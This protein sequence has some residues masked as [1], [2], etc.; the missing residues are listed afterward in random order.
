[1]WTG[2]NC[3]AS[4]PNPRVLRACLFKIWKSPLRSRSGSLA[5]AAP[6]TGLIR[7]ASL[8]S[9]AM[10]ARCK[11]SAGANWPWS[12]PVALS[13]PRCGNQ[14]AQ[15]WMRLP[16]LRTT[17]A[18]RFWLWPAAW[19]VATGCVNW[20]KKCRKWICGCQ[21]KKCFFGRKC[22]SKPLAGAAN[23]PEAG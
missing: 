1:M 4:S 8:A 21:P 6:K 19:S 12:I 13:S 15:S 17:S 14:S 16:K 9:W 10:C 3:F 5:W 7:N 20:P 2:K 23:R 11:A 22:F 18:V